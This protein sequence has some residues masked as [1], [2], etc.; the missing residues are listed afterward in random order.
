MN[1]TFFKVPTE[2]LPRLAAAYVPVETGIRKLQPGETLRY[3]MPTGMT[4]ISADYTTAKSNKYVSGGAGLSSTA[5]DYERF[6]QMLLGQGELD[7]VR[8]LREETFRLMATSSRDGLSLPADSTEG[9]SLW[10]IM[11]SP[12]T[13]E[14][15][16]QLR[17]RYIANGFWST[18]ASA[19]SGGDWIVIAMTQLAYDDKASPKWFDQYDEIAAKAIEK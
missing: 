11:V 1:D 14:V 10:T 12:S 7:G 9:F 13:P 18:H 3:E 4:M 8:L 17:G 19:S 16:E 15:P 6:C 2:K 5:A